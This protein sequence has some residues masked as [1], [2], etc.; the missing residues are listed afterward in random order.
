MYQK[1]ENKNSHIVPNGRPQIDKTGYLQ[2]AYE[3][4]KNIYKE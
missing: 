3:F 4:G 1:M 2:K